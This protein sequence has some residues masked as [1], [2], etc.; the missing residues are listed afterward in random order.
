MKSFKDFLKEDSDGADVV[1]YHGAF[2]TDLANIDNVGWPSFDIGNPDVLKRLNQYIASVSLRSWIDYME[3]IRF[4]YN[5]LMQ[6]GLTFDFPNIQKI[7]MATENGGYFINVPLT[8]YGGPYGTDQ[9]FSFDMLTTDGIESKVGTPLVL[10]ID[11]DPG[12]AG[13]YVVS[14][15]I[16]A[17]D[18]EEIIQPES[19]EEMLDDTV[20]DEF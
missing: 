12:E 2:G 7:L 17:P 20:Q 5:R 4:I 15:C 11:V 19:P 3:P 13:R 8:Q 10:K 16:E 6:T 18:S 9:D 14:V 1:G